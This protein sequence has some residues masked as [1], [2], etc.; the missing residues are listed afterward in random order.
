MCQAAHLKPL[1]PTGC[2]LPTQLGSVLCV[3]HVNTVAV[4]RCLSLPPTP[5]ASTGHPTII[6]SAPVTSPRFR[7]F[8]RRRR[9]HRLIGMSIVLCTRRCD[10]SPDYTPRLQHILAVDRA[11]L[12]FFC[13]NAWLQRR[14]ARSTTFTTMDSKTKAPK[15]TQ[16]IKPG[17]VVIL[18]N[19]RYAGAKVK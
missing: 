19:G 3:S 17:K 12:H 13:C 8:L 7:R 18:L 9:R 4:M 11:G 16:I 6:T 14:I 5:T 2:A 15:T 10:H 1:S